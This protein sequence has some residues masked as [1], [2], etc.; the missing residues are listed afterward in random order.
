MV[1]KLAT[2]AKLKFLCR[3]R[4]KRPDCVSRIFLKKPIDGLAGLRDK[5]G[6]AAD[7][8]AGSDDED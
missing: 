2:V 8:A 7:E 3:E 4:E 5:P 6:L 1:S